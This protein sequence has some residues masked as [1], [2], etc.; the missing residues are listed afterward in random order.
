MAHAGVVDKV[1]TMGEGESEGDVW[2]LRSV[3]DGVVGGTSGEGSD[4]R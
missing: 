3:G 1:D 4:R 2:L